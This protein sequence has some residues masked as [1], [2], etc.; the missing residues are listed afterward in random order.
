M[1][2]RFK[3]KM[4]QDI[5]ELGLTGTYPIP[6]DFNKGVFGGSRRVAWE[7][8]YLGRKV[9]RYGRNTI[10][11]AAWC[12]GKE[13]AKKISDSNIES[14]KCI[15]CGSDNEPFKNGNI[16]KRCWY[17]MNSLEGSKG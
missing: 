11:Y 10:A 15:C 13:V 9:T 3:D 8:G 2:P 17:C 4:M 14:V 12:A 5:Y 16:R 7:N 1:K 6:V